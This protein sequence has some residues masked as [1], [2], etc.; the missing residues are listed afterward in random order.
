MK[1]L[2][3]FL[4]LILISITLK[5]QENTAKKPDVNIKVNREFDKNGNVLKYDSTYTWSWSGNTNIS[6]FDS[7]SSKFPDMIKYKWFSGVEP[8]ANNFNFSDTII[9]GFDNNFDDFEKQMFEMFEK[10][11]N[12][13]NEMFKQFENNNLPNIEN[14][15]Q[16]L[17]KNKE[18]SKKIDL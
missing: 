12:V 10:Q 1:Y 8:F 7:L 18:D 14:K 15:E 5:A 6:N 3:L 4:S 11:Q 17:P 9:N 16:S 13:F 2:I